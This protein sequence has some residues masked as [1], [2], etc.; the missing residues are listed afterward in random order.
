MDNA[1]QAEFGTWGCPGPKRQ[2]S[3]APAWNQTQQ[4]PTPTC[5]AA[6]G[7]V[8]AAGN[9]TTGEETWEGNSQAS[10]SRK[11][12][13]DLLREQGLCPGHFP[14]PGLITEAVLGSCVTDGWQVD[15][16]AEWVGKGING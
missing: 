13:K 3:Q 9:P 7:W 5:Q 14:I 10:L 6:G 16:W 12:N 15:A 4:P 1:G 11:G 8:S 2:S